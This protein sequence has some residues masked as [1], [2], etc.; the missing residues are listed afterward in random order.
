MHVGL[1]LP[2]SHAVAVPVDPTFERMERVHER[3][4]AGF[5]RLPMLRDRTAL[6]QHAREIR[7]L[8]DIDGTTD[9]RPSPP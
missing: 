3:C 2:S 1:A 8:T 5:L 4:D 7:L 6:L 9:P